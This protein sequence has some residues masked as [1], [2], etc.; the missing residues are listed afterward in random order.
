MKI[1]SKYFWAYLYMKSSFPK[2]HKSILIVFLPRLCYYDFFLYEHVVN[3]KI[4]LLN[5]LLAWS[6]H[7]KQSLLIQTF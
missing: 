4:F 2:R 1:V 7:V 3:M 6:E 5:G